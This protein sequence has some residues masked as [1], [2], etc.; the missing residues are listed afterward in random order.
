MAQLRVRKK[1]VPV[2][3]PTSHLV[4]IALVL[5]AGIATTVLVENGNQTPAAIAEATVPWLTESWHAAGV[6][7]ARTQTYQVDKT[8]WVMA[9]HPPIT[10]FTPEEL[11]AIGRSNGWNLVANKTRG[12]PTLNASAKAYDRLYVELGQGRYGALRWRDVPR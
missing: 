12:V 6:T 10:D 8:V 5:A 4:P 7:V 1:E 9:D 2:A 11:V 3:R